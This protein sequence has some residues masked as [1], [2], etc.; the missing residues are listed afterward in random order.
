[1]RILFELLPLMFAT[2]FIMWILLL[3]DSPKECSTGTKCPMGR[4]YIRGVE[5]ETKNWSSS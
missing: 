2:F 4:E 1:M 5:A 3:N